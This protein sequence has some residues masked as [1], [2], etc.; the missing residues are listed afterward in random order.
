MKNVKRISLLGLVNVLVS[1]DVNKGCNFIGFD[2]LTDVKLKGG[3]SNPQQGL[4]QKEHNGALGILFSN[5]NGSSYA[6]MVNRRLEAE[7]KEA[8]FEAGKLP[9]GNRVQGTAVIEHKGQF[10][11]QVIYNQKA[12]NLLQYVEKSGIV[13]SKSDTDL[14][15][16]MKN[17]IVG[18]ESKNGTINYKLNG[19]EI[20][21]DEIIGLPE[22]KSN[23]KQGGLSEDFK[24][25][26]RT[27]K[28]SSLT[29]IRVNGTQYIIED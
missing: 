25:I 26:V 6:K 28:L 23:G 1:K 27:F 11:V 15:E 17:T 18:F 10:Y 14:V 12:V 22:S 21:K 7:G 13:L 20:A 8:N 4:V 5:K 2:A 9:W 3:K 29:S 24:V 19:E 16:S